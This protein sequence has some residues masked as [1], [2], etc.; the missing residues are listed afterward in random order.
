MSAAEDLAAYVKA[1]LA[2]NDEACLRIEFRYGLDGYSP[3][4]VMIGLNAA[5]HGK[6][7]HEAI[8]AF[9]ADKEAES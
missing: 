4:T 1:M 8:S 3:Q 7:A 2:N 5:V 6:D 9:F